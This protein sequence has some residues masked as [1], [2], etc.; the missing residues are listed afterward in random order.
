MIFIDF[1]KAFDSIE[2]CFLYKCLAVFNFV[3]EFIKWVKTFYKIV[4]S[5]VINHLVSSPTFQLGRGVRQGAPLSP[6]LF[7]TVI[8][9]LVIFIKS[10]TNIKG[11]K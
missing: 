9:I 3:P 6:Y 4:S 2:W 11:I 5:C 7:V 8:E 10:N 1:E